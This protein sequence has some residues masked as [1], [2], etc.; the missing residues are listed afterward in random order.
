MSDSKAHW[1]AIHEQIAR[2][3]F[4]LGVAT[5]NALYSDPKM[6]GFIAARY[7]FV[8]K[9]IAGMPEVVEIGCGDAFGAPIVAQAVGTVTC[10]DIDEPTLEDNRLRLAEIKNIKFRY[11]D[12]R[13][14]PV[15]FKTDAAYAVDVIEHIFPEEEAKFLGNIVAG[16]TDNGILVV[17]TPNLTAEAYA[18][19]LSRKGH[20]NLKDQTSLRATM[21]LY[22]NNVFM[23]G[24]ND[25]VIHTGF[26]PMAHYIWALCVGPRRP[27]PK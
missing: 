22:F 8:A 9:L 18:S 3:P 21:M 10:T 20:V 7:K 13:Q 24:M 2:R 5:S 15:P 12:F 25:E 19:E 26:A 17:G 14:G 23:F 16:L 27:E 11:H 6:L 1:L 4:G